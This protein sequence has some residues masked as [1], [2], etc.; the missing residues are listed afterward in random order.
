VVIAA[1]HFTRGNL[2]SYYEI[3]RTHCQQIDKD[4]ADCYTKSLG[5]DLRL[6]H[7]KINT[8]AVEQPMA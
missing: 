1:L 7:T 6:A 3:Y 4:F 8:P 2:I 5:V